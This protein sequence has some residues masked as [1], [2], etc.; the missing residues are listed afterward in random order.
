MKMLLAAAVLRTIS[1]A[2]TGS[3]LFDAGAWYVVR[4]AL[5]VYVP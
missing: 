1:A 3:S 5:A 4:P 2:N